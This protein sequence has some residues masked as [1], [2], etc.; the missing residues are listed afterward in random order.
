[1]EACLRNPGRS[2]R[3]LKEYDAAMERARASFTWFIYR[4]R[5]PAMRNLFMSP[6]NWFRME[7]AV[8]SLLAGDMF[9]GW[10]IRSRLYMFRGIYYITKL[11]H[12]RH[13]VRAPR[14]L[15]GQASVEAAG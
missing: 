15:G 3:V 8:L 13:R 7:E 11:A 10:R 12:L 2:A 9:G 6:R 1:V 4:I 5:E 14:K